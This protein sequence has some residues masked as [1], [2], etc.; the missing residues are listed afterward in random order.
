M[1]ENKS[2]LPP[3]PSTSKKA[4]IKVIALAVTC[5]VLA[6][7]LVATLAI[8]QPTDLK[9][10]VDSK[11]K[12]I[13]DLQAQITSLTSQFSLNASNYESEIQSL[14]TQLDNMTAELNTAQGQLTSAA[15]IMTM[16]ATQTLV[17]SK[18]I[19][20]ATDIYD[21]TLTY[22]GYVAVQVTSNSSATFVQASYSVSG[23][24]YNEN[25]TVGK[26]GTAAFPVLPTTV[27]IKVA[28]SDKTA[29]N[30]TVTATFYY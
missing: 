25:V 28:T 29:F 21:N 27:D 18:G 26:S 15:T 12:Q 10:Q 9:S 19:S 8:Y 22:P 23:V 20:N 24:N 2:E 4:N 13:S 11:N 6:A 1:G 14:N 17:D 16:K 30:A 7:S 5:V 3:P